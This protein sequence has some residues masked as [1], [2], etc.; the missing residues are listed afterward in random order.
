MTCKDGELAQ[1]ETAQ[2]MPVVPT[3]KVAV[4]FGE[5]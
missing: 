1:T 4:L 5:Q 2:Y 3:A